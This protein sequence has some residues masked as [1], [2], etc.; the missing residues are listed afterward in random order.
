MEVT[1]DLDNPWAMPYLAPKAPTTQTELANSLDDLCTAFMAKGS[2]KLPQ[3]GPEV[4]NNPG[5]FSAISVTETT[6]DPPLVP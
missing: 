1:N 5:N 4:A 2:P 3:A 6:P